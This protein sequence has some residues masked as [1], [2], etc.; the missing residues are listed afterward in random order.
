MH[1]IGL[2][3]LILRNR[4][5][6]NSRLLA[7]V[8]VL[9]CGGV[10]SPL[11]V[12]QSERDFTVDVVVTD[13]GSQQRDSA[14]WLAL[15][16]VLRRNVETRIRVET[17]QRKSLLKNPSRFVQSFRYRKFDSISDSVRLS[18]RSVREGAPAGAVIMV[19]FPT[20]LAAI[21]QQQLLPQAVVEE[22]EVVK[23]VL[24]LVAVELGANQF[25]IGGD[26]GKKFQTRA[27]QLAAANNLQLQF[28]V[29]EAAAS[30]LIT[31]ADVMAGDVER[32]SNFVKQFDSD[33]YLTGALYRLNENT[34]QSDWSY[35]EDNGQPQSFGLSTAT[36]DEALVAAMTQISPTGG[37]LASPYSQGSDA[38][39]QRS[40]FSVRVENIR[41]LADYDNVLALL[42]R[43]D[44]EIVTEKLES[45]SMVFRG[46]DQSAARVRDSLI[47]DR[48]FE[49]LEVDRFSDDLSFRYQAR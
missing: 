16:Q 27:L 24:A 17:D 11:A 9:F 20:D 30:E 29:V 21:V 25:I 18:T 45:D 8:L 23:P 48:S 33:S 19:T 42:R 34:W 49:P 28:P 10:V 4:V 46:T 47:A 14:Y 22:P 6:D 2:L 37:F 12:A 5:T 32:I 43:L 26:R 3:L 41:S 13:Q 38:A 31:A 15:D 1:W 7:I 35:T 40:G 39:F 36:L 44:S